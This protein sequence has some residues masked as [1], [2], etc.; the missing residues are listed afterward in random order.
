[1]KNPTLDVFNEKN[2]GDFYESKSDEEEKKNTTKRSKW[3]QNQIFKKRNTKINLNS[4]DYAHISIND[5]TTCSENAEP[6]LK[7]VEECLD[8]CKHLSVTNK[9]T[10]SAYGVLNCTLLDTILA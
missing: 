10:I 2:D 1:M 3:Q 9:P 4:S 8:M 5:S 6:S 7:E